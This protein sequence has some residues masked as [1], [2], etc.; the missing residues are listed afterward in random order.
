ME[1]HFRGPSRS[2][3]ETSLASIARRKKA[4]SGAFFLS[5]SRLHFNRRAPRNLPCS[6]RTVG[7]SVP[8]VTETVPKNGDNE[9]HCRSRNRPT[10]RR[11]D[12]ISGQRKPIEG[13][14][15][16][17]SAL[18]VPLSPSDCCRNTHMRAAVESKRLDQGHPPHIATQ[19][20]KGFRPGTCPNYRPWLSRSIGLF[21]RPILGIAYR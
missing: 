19:A 14:F 5:D 9:F 3:P 15:Y 7:I 13:A 16:L 10:I 12:S 1:Q 6:L 4:P 2:R 20:D 18:R 17:L 21:C 11:P 8:S